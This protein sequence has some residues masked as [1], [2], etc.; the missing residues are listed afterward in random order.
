MTA[1]EKT[2]RK[3]QFIFRA[4][5]SGEYACLIQRGRVEL[6]VDRDGERVVIAIVGAQSLFGELALIDDSVRMASARALETTICHLIDKTQLTIRLR[7]LTAGQRD[8]FQAMIDYVRATPTTEERAKRKDGLIETPD[9]IRLR[10]LR[11][12]PHLLDR[13]KTDDI[14]VTALGEILVGYV[15]R[16]LPQILSRTA[17][18]RR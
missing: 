8:L 4:G 1:I 18:D 9:D 5:E 2:Y 3:G 11:S 16:R 14:F 17:S 15:D 12:Q 13:L 6:L 7:Q 10:T